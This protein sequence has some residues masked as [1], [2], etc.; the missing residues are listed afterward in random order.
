MH[1]RRSKLR[2]N[3]VL[4]VTKVDREERDGVSSEVLVQNMIEQKMDLPLTKKTSQKTLSS[5]H[6][7]S[8]RSV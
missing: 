2:W 4:I 3:W 5:F 8:S 7:K 1:R 6:G